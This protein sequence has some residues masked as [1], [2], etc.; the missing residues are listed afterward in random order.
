MCMC[1]LPAMYVYS[2]YSVSVWEPIKG[3][4][5]PQNWSYSLFYLTTYVLRIEFGSYGVVASCL[6]H[7]AISPLPTL[8]V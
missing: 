6:N 7:Q 2:A 8:C 4:Q 1:V 5:S 3:Y